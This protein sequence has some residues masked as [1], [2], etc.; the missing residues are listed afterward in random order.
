MRNNRSK[1]GTLLAAVLWTII[2]VVWGVITVTRFNDPATIGDS[3]VLTI[4]TMLLS[5]AL[6]VIFWIRFARYGKK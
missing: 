5:L 4:F 6:C 1:G 3:L 2:A